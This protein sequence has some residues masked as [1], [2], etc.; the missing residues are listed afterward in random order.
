[1]HIGMVYDLKEDYGIDNDDISYCDFSNLIEMQHI[2]QLLEQLGHFVSMVGSPMDFTNEIQNKSY[3]KYD[4]IFNF[5]EGFKS[6]NRESLVP[7]LC[8]LFKIPYTFSDCHA[9]DLT[10][11][12]HQLLLF[13]EN[14][15]I[16]IPKGFLFIPDVHNQSYIQQKCKELNLCFPIV[17]KPNREG[18]SMGLAFSSSLQELISNVEKTVYT[19]QQEVRCDEYITGHEIA[20]PILGSGQKANA[21]GFVEYQKHDGSAIEHY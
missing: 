8:E 15:G 5:A 11:H 16:A 2:Q 17:S 14:L 1:M 19:Y 18:T 21:L 9:M 20:V 13:A 10:L 3:K 4:L 6:R 7:A 12:K